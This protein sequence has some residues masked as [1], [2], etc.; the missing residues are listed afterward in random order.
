MLMPAKT[1]SL[2]RIAIDLQSA[3]YALR[4]NK[5]FEFSVIAVIVFSAVTIGMRTY[6]LP[7]LLISLVGI[8][9]WVITAVFLLEIIV[10]FVGE[11]HKKKVFLFCLEYFR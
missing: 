6:D 9:D 10:R 2:R 4:H 5:I 7:P 11:P 3:F 8:L 1:S